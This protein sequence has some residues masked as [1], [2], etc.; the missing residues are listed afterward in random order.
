[1]VDLLTKIRNWA[2]QFSLAID[3]FNQAAA[4]L[5]FLAVI[6]TFLLQ[7]TCRYLFSW[8]F[9]W[10]LEFIR[11]AYMYALFLGIAIAFRSGE[12]MLFEALFDLFPENV[13]RTMVIGT[14][15]ACLAFFVFM[16][17]YGLKLFEFTSFYT[18][19]GLPISRKWKVLPVAISGLLM[20]IHLFPLL[21]SDLIG[22]I[23]DRKQGLCF[24]GSG[25]CSYVRTKSE[26]Q[27]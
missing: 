26:E 4:F 12:H 27:I 19:M 11:F 2:I 21:L 15:I 23:Q 5:A 6:L 20:L 1:M 25:D 13:R 17:I 9:P 24:F 14:H 10:G 8:S 22:L 7:I 3:K 18:M 16:F